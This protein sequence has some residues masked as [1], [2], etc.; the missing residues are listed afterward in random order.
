M[1]ARSNHAYRCKYCL[2]YQRS[3]PSIHEKPDAPGNCAAYSEIC[4]C[5]RFRRNVGD[6]LAVYVNSDL[7]EGFYLPEEINRHTTETKIYFA[8]TAVLIVY[9]IIMQFA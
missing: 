4:V 3:V 6:E 5:R 7:N 8:I 9:G 1:K 2:Y